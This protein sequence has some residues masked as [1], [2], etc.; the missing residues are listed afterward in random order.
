MSDAE[1]SIALADILAELYPLGP[2]EEEIWVRAGGD[3]SRLQLSGTGR[4]KWF[5]ALRTLRH[6]GGG[7]S[8]SRNTL[9]RT[10]LSDFPR[11]P[12]LLGLATA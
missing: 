3:L 12:I 10:A 4:A 8:I 5:S 6:G 9:T 7:P 2:I 11:H 1:V